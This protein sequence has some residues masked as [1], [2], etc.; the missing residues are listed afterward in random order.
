MRRKCC[1]QHRDRTVG[2]FLWS[3]DVVGHHE[4][5]FERTLEPACRHLAGLDVVNYLLSVDDL[6]ISINPD[7]VTC[8][9][10]PAGLIELDLISFDRHVAVF[11][12]DIAGSRCDT[13]VLVVIR[14]VRLDVEIRCLLGSGTGN[15]EAA[16]LRRCLENTAFQRVRK[17][18]PRLH[19]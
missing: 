8:E 2:A 5:W 18:D 1:I 13:E 4:D 7:I 9:Y 16:I 11:H 14:E 6:T 15:F 19:E 12:D 17:K 10:I 3:G